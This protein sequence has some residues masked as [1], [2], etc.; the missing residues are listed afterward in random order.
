M[1][2]AS[3]RSALSH[4]A[5]IAAASRFVDQTVATSSRPS[6][7]SSHLSNSLSS[8][9]VGLPSFQSVETLAGLLAELAPS[10][11]AASCDAL[12]RAFQDFADV[13]ADV[14]ADGVGKF[15]RAHRHAEGLAAASSSF[16]VG[17]GFEALEGFEHV[18]REHAVDEKARH[19]LHDQAGTSPIAVTKAQPLSI[20]LVAAEP[21]RE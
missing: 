11:Q 9:R 15:D 16:S 1:T 12:G 6:A 4:D 19:A 8:A 10:R 20:S 17:A 13:G 3:T 2:P 21:C 18:G 5:F 14:E 7:S